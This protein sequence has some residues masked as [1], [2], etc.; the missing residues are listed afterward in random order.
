M[1]VVIAL[2]GKKGTGKSTIRKFLESYFVYPEPINFADI[3]RKELV[4][5]GAPMNKLTTQEGKLEPVPSDILNKL[6]DDLPWKDSIK[7]YRE[8]MQAWGTYRREQDPN[9]WT[10]MWKDAVKQVTV[11]D[12]PDTVVICDD[13]RYPNELSTIRSLSTNEENIVDRTIIVRVAPYPE[14]S[15]DEYSFHISETALDQAQNQFDLRFSPPYGEDYLKAVAKAIIAYTCT[16]AQVYT[17]GEEQ[18]DAL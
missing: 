10:K 14:Y 1:S 3:L 16:I 18:N 4:A 17:T 9:Y 6:P 15:Y 13:L 11:Y 5:L 2:S 8:L 12:N 7:S